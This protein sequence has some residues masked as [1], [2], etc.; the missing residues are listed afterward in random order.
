MRKKDKKRKKR[1]ETEKIT[2]TK[3]IVVLVIVTHGEQKHKL[4]NTTVTLPE[5]QRTQ[6]IES[7]TGVNLS[8]RIVQD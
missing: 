3:T 5:A 6:G 7:I 8:A 1:G 2:R 4:Q